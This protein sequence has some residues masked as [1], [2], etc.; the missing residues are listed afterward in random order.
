MKFEENIAYE[1]LKSYEEQQSD[2]EGKEKISVSITGVPYKKIQY[3]IIL[4]RESGYLSMPVTNE[5]NS[6]RL[7]FHGHKFLDQLRERF[8]KSG[9]SGVH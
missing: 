8:E 1:I 5:F 4:L 2:V 6:G 7:T 9:R 3:H